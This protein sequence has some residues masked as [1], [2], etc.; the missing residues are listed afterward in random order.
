MTIQIGRLLTWSLLIAWTLIGLSFMAKVLFSKETNAIQEAA[1][2]AISGT[3]IIAGYVIAR[4]INKILD[5]IKDLN[6]PKIPIGEMIEQY[7][8]HRKK[9][10]IL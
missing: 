7:M 8:Q 5:E 6:L 2:A 10:N 9:N 3:F 1:A 4:A